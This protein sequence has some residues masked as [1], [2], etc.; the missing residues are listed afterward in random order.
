MAK[1]KFPFGKKQ[2]KEVF[3]CVYAGPE[4]F[5]RQLEKNKMGMQSEQPK[6][7]N[8]G[9]SE[10]ASGATRKFCGECGKL[11]DGGKFCPECGAKVEEEE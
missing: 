11:L 9:E 2:D 10:Q 5:E 4:Y 6:P 3:E 1:I 8:S 7:E